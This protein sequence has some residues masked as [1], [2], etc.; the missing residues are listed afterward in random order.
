MTET[1][2]KFSFVHIYYKICITNLYVNLRVS[3]THLPSA[4][5]RCLRRAA[6]MAADRRTTGNAGGSRWMWAGSRTGRGKG[7]WGTQGSL[8]K[9]GNK[10]STERLCFGHYSKN[11]FFDTLTRSN[12][13]QTINIPEIRQPKKCS[14][15]IFRKMVHV[16][17]Q[18][19]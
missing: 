8:Q 15:L 17:F 4:A 3:F 12:T 2:A 13:S 14:Y 5:S 7:P 9:K 6:L 18:L 19:G 11:I 10:V 1:E 16:W